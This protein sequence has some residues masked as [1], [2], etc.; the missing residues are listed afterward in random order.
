MERISRFTV[1]TMAACALLLATVPARATF[2]GR[3]GRIAFARDRGHGAEIYTM[4]RTGANI[5][6]LTNFDRG[7]WFPFWSPDGSKIV[8]ELDVPDDGCGS[9]MLMNADGTGPVDLTAVSDRLRDVCGQGPSFMPNGHR[10]VFEGGSRL[11][12]FDGIWSFDVHGR[13]V[14]RLVDSTRVQRLVP[15]DITLKSP[16]VSP[17]GKTLLFE[18]EHFLSDGTNEKALFTLRMNGHDLREIV[19]FSDDVSIKG[20]EWSPD[21]ERILFSDN[22]GYAGQTVF[23]E[24]QNVYTIGADGTGL[25]QLT[26]FHAVPPDVGTGAASYSPDGRWITFK[27]GSHGRSSIWKMHPTGTHLTRIIR[28]KFGFSGAVVWGPQA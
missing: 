17:D 18:V 7:A 14:E 8:F 9:I 27:H 2:P 23:T 21:G 12:S 10:I 28:S 25:L 1:V 5:R 22:A 13:H 4:S 24:P 6:R 11:R 3:D 26:H 16:R 19:P 20:G 15:G